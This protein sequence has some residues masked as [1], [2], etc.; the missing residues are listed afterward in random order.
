MANFRRQY[1]YN[2]EKHV[3]FKVAPNIS[4]SL[5]AIFSCDEIGKEVKIQ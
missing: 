2:L 5:D 1:Y 3:G 4:S